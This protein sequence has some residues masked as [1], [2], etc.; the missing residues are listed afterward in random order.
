MLDHLLAKVFGTQN[1]RDLKRVQPTVTAINDLEDTIKRL[2]DEELRDKTV[3]FKQQ[4]A[5]GATLDDL[6]IE[7]FATVREAGW[8]VLKMRHFD[9][10][11]IG[12]MM[13]HSGKIAEMNRRRKDAGR[14]ACRL[15]KRIARRWCSCRHGQRLSRPARRRLDG[16]HLPISG[17]D[18]RCH[19]T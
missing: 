12:G 19:P 10:Q 2:S 6:L 5:Q 18:R 1:E 11:L 4:I 9:V 3:D 7:A 15:S 17:N 14:H 13:L 8:R 16:T